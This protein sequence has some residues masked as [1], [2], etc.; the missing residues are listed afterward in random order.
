MKGE[1]KMKNTFKALLLLLSLMLVL[2]SLSLPVFA[3]E[4]P[5]DED[6]II[7][8]SGDST[9]NPVKSTYTD[10]ED[11]LILVFGDGREYNVTKQ[12]WVTEPAQTED[13]KL[14]FD[15]KRMFSSLDYMWQGMLCIFV[16]I[17][18]II[19]TVYLIGHF[20]SKAEA[21]KAAKDESG[22]AEDQ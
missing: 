16:V 11:N 4:Q 3:V 8:E 9:D 10:E 12:E 6:I 17:G 21:R 22:E 19:L 1:C 18:A 5:D 13:M 15:I 7:G 20:S 14:G 2:A